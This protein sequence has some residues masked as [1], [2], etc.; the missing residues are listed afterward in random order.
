MGYHD[1]SP[2][3]LLPVHEARTFEPPYWNILRTDQLATSMD[4]FYTVS[5]RNYSHGDHD[6]LRIHRGA[7][8]VAR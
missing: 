2:A 8:E 6:V 5:L 7:N 1:S 4:W 3:R